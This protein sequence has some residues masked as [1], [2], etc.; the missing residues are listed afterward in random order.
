MNTQVRRAAA[1]LAVHAASKLRAL[2]VVDTSSRK[3][4]MTFQHSRNKKAFIDD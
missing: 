4:C 1:H 3:R 2:M